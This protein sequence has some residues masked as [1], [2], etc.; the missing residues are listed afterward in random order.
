MPPVVPNKGHQHPGS[1]ISPVTHLRRCVTDP[2][3]RLST[4]SGRSIEGEDDIEIDPMYHPS[5]NFLFTFPNWQ[6]GT[7]PLE[8]HKSL[9]STVLGKKKGEGRRENSCWRVRHCGFCAIEAGT[10]P[11]LAQRG[12]WV[13]SDNHRA[14]S[15]AQLDHDLLP[16]TAS[17]IPTPKN[18]ASPAT[19]SLEPATAMEAQ[20][21]SPASNAT[22]RP[23]G[24]L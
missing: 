13:T 22:T 18:A 3:H 2:I 20:T 10:R 11:L 9:S 16:I 12:P 24:D 17:A 5:A 1:D 14:P 23:R 19:A 4:N 15:N 7:C 8:P 6:A 21:P